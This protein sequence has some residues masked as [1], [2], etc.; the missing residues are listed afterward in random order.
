MVQPVVDAPQIPIDFKVNENDSKA[1]WAV[2]MSAKPFG[3]Q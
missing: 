1:Q 3:T 2:L